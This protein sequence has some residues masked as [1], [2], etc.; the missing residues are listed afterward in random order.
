MTQV[1]TVRG[2]TKLWR[3]IASASD[4]SARSGSSEFARS[5][6]P[7]AARVLEA[8]GLLNEESE[9]FLAPRLAHLHDPS[10]LPDMDRAAER[11]LHAAASKQPIAIYGDYDVDGVTAS[12]ILA[13]TLRAIHPESRVITY[14]P[15]R[16]DEGYGLNAEAIRSLAEAGATVVVTVDCGITANGPAMVARDLGIDLIITDHH[17]GAENQADLPPAYAIVHPRRPGSVYPF[18]DLCGAGVA[19]KLAWRLCTMHAGS[20]RIPQLLRDLLVDLLGLA[21]LG[22]IADVVPLLGEN[23][24]IVRSGL[25]R[26]RTSPFIGLRAL[27]KASG[28]DG[29]RIDTDGVGFSLAPRLNA[30]GRLGHAREALEL[31]LTDDPGRAAE[32]ARELTRLNDNRRAVEKQIAEQAFELARESGMLD[33]DTRAIVLAHPEWHTGVIGIVCSRLVERTGR[34]TIL[35]QHQGDML[36]G[37]GRSIDGYSLHAA[38]CECSPHLHTFGG[39]DMAAGLKLAPDKLE[40]FRAAFSSHAARMLNPEDLIPRVQFDCDASIRDLTPLAIR[41]LE[42]LAPFGRENPPVRVRLTGLRV[43]AR[44]EPFGKAGGHIK[45]TVRD[46]DRSLRVIGWNWASRH[47]QTA[48]SIPVGTRID[49]LVI[50]KLSTWSGLVEPELV[51]LQHG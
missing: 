9:K 31:M 6:E 3:A 43:S 37:S 32:I 38:L 15:H 30:C 22:A 4:T 24:V 14:I 13:R 23:R 10:L 29:D 16:I 41:Q 21:A 8:R 46:G 28:L 26:I 49:A 27:V 17:N 34:P 45:L 2:F 1:H 42:L 20:A 51:D 7:L 35:L 33:S 19:Y 48:A 47:P 39:H 12:A 18:G 50:P 11:I 40:A 25:S 36:A 5:Y 44:P